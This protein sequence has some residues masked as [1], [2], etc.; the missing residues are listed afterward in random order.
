MA[1]VTAALTWQP[2]QPARALDDRLRQAGATPSLA[3]D[4]YALVDDH[5]TSTLEVVYP[6]YG[7]LGRGR[8]DA[9]VM[10]VARQT[11][12]TAAGATPQTR[13]LTIDVRLRHANRRWAAESASVSAPPPLAASLDAATRRLLGNDGV[14]LPAAARADLLSGAI[15]PRLVRVLGALSRTWRI[16]VQV[17]RSG[18][19]RNV[20][21]T[22]RLSN[23]T[24]GQAVDV[25]A[26]DDIPV[27]EQR[28]SVASAV[29]RQAAAA[30]ADEIGGPLDPDGRNGRP[31]YFTNDVHKDHIHV[32]FEVR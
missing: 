12:R 10:I 26:I 32:G 28:A 5:L 20:Y 23:H 21:G 22:A 25:W 14:V 19:P 15:D 16:H 4:L 30:G 6:Q 3:P 2:G 1:A 27:I 17:L 11:W 9:S 18:H 8:R 13:E 7:G 29:M 24:R 31:P